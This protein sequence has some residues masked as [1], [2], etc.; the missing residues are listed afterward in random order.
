LT[1]NDLIDQKSKIQQGQVLKKQRRSIIFRAHQADSLGTSIIEGLQNSYPAQF[2]ILSG[3]QHFI[4][5][6]NR[7]AEF[8]SN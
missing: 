3:Q 4:C 1:V 5:N 2:R 6:I 8:H 7:T